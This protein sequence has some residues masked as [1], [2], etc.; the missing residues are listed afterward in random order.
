MRCAP[1]MLTAACAL[2]SC[3]NWPQYANMPDE[4]PL[5][6][7]STDPGALI[8]VSWAMHDTEPSPNDLPADAEVQLTLGANHGALFAG[9]LDGVGWSDD[10]APEPIVSEACGST[11]DRSPLEHGDYIG[12][13]D[14][15]PLTVDVEG[16]ALL[17]AEARFGDDSHGW[18]L[19]LF[20]LDPCGVPGEPIEADDLVLGLGLGGESAGWAQV[21]AAGSYAVM[22]ASYYP[23]DLDA[24]PHYVLAMSVVAPDPDGSDSVCPTAPFDELEGA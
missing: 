15:F 17:C 13:V 24:S 6:P 11:G 20:P 16:E 1:W 3:A 21:V 7:S 23:N 8:V 12:D 5:V 2:A 14:F 22:L 19:L 10:A 9:A 4:E 18:D